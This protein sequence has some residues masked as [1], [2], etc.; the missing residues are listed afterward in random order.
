MLYFPSWQTIL[1]LLVVALGV[2]FAA[3]IVIPA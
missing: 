1:I 3:P 2:A